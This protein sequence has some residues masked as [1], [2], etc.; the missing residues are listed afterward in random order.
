MSTA[1]FV[2]LTGGRFDPQPQVATP[3]QP[4]DPERTYY[5]MKLQLFQLEFRVSDTTRRLDLS[6][7]R[8][9][10]LEGREKSLKDMVEYHTGSSVQRLA[11][12]AKAKAKEL[13]EL[14]LVITSER[15]HRDAM[16]RL[17]Q[18][19]ED[20]L[21]AFPRKKFLDLKK[22]VATITAADQ[23]PKA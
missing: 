5:Q 21:A 14:Q 10:E 2:D 9:K 13:A 23:K 4:E 7:A 11:L 22:I 18:A 6:N 19:S 3:P 8:L 20:A 12:I 1:T 17:L 16:V 15:N